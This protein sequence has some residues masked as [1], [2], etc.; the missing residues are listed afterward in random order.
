MS[1]GRAFAGWAGSPG[2]RASYTA[3]VRSCACS[4]ATRGLS[5]REPRGAMRCMECVQC[6]RACH[7][8]ERARG[9]AAPVGRGRRLWGAAVD[10]QKEPE[11]LAIQHALAAGCRA[12]VQRDADLTGTRGRR[13]LGS[14]RISRPAALGLLCRAKHHILHLALS[15][16]A[17]ST[18]SCQPARP[19]F[20]HRGPR[21]L[22]RTRALALSA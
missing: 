10:A 12:S 19:N 9:L 2:L 1:A 14:A 16:L 8:S 6:T 20:A 17:D 5:P 15:R 18:R 11:H 3:A 7:P 13:S 22:G 21:S 4:T